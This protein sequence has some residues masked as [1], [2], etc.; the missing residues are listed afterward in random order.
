MSGMSRAQ[1]RKLIG[2][3]VVLPPL[4]A[5]HV[6]PPAPFVALGLIDAASVTVLGRDVADVAVSALSGRDCSVVRLDRGQSYCRPLE[7]PPERPEFCTRSLGRADCWSN[8]EALPGP[9]REIADGRW[10]LTEEQ[11]Q[12]RTRQWPG[13]W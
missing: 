6:V 9:V 4:S 11:E 10:T 3:L 13:L 5:C 1:L 7:P 8:P 12:N 2:L